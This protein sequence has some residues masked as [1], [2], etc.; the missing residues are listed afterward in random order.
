MLILSTWECEDSKYYL[1]SLFLQYSPSNIRYIQ[2]CSVNVHPVPDT[3]FYI[4]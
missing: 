3:H 2:Q 1:S 4:F